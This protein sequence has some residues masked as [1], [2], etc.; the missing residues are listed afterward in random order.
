MRALL[1]ST[2]RM[3]GT[4]S[5]LTGYRLAQLGLAGLLAGLVS[6]CAVVEPYER[7]NL[8]TYGMRPDRDQLAGR[9][10]D[11]LWFSREAANG[12]GRVGGGGCGC[13]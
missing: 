11:H 9:L 2:I 13:N 10:Q 5:A 4:R 6:G 7:E 3:P 8:A 12:G 1:K